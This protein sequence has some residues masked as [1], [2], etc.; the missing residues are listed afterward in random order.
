MSKKL[1]LIY[2][3]QPRHLR[4]CHE[5]HVENFYQKGW[6]VDVFAHV[7]YDKSWVGA[8][9]WDQ[10]K[11][12]GRWDAELIPYMEENWKPKALE[13]EEPKNLK[14]IGIL[15]L[16]FLIQLI[17]LSQCFIVSKRLIILRKNMK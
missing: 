17:I 3:G 8:Y 9:F 7:W 16:D 5:N 6:D 11:D 13:F 2:S 10:Y 15:I 4:E 1:A 14:V 12:R